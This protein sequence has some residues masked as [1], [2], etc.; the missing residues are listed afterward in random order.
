WHIESNFDA[1]GIFN[2][3]WQNNNGDVATWQANDSVLLGN[4]GFVNTGPSWQA[5]DTG[6]YDGNGTLDTL[7]QSDAGQ[8]AIWLMGGATPNFKVVVDFNPSTTWHLQAG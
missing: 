3:L 1:N 5:I 4:A 8:K 7:W 6:D 2:V